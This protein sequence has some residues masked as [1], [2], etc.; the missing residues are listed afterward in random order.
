MYYNKCKSD[1]LC[2]LKTEFFSWIHMAIIYLF[3]DT[4]LFIQCKSLD[5]LDWSAWKAFDEIHL[6][7]S[8]PVQAEID[9][10]KGGGNSRLSHR[11][12]NT[13]SK[14][15]REILNSQEGYLELRNTRPVV[16]IYLRQ[17]LKRDESLAEQLD[18][19]EHDDQLVGI[20]SLFSKN[21]A[22]AE[23][24]VLTHDTGPMTTA[25]MVGVK[26][27][28]IPEIWLLPPE[29][30]KHEKQI[31]A[32]QREIDLLKKTEPEI[33]I[34]FENPLS[35]NDALDIQITHYTA[36][37]HVKVES[38]ISRIKNNIP[39]KTKFNLKEQQ[40][41]TRFH[42]M[43]SLLQGTFVPPT[44][45]EIQI[46]ANESYPNW[47]G[48]CEEILFYLHE[49]I[50]AKT[51]NPEVTVLL[52]NE[53]SRPA[54]DV[55]IT[56]SAKGDFKIQPPLDPDEGE[57]ED[58]FPEF[59][60]PLPPS[61]PSGRRKN[62]FA[63]GEL[64]SAFTR[65]TTS[66]FDIT[67]LT[68]PNEYRRDPNKF[69]YQSKPDTPVQAFSLTCSQWRHQDE[70]E[71]FIFTMHTKAQT[72]KQFSGELEIKVQAANLTNPIIMR[73][74]IKISFTLKSV[75]SEAE[76]L[77]NQLIRKSRF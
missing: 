35:S 61:P 67:R 45:E 60:L 46:Y 72:E 56:L 57:E 32:L 12:R 75:F 13:S 58:S 37:D 2:I 20:A 71:P 47:L 17:D 34:R 66:S 1:H 74:H 14:I 55:L 44:E 73:K 69:Y 29:A 48:K 42:H 30:T 39:L 76:K 6:L 26:F 27:T 8:R 31:K 36:L 15:F 63:L 7:V 21:N 59:E 77:V 5:E 52:S 70:E 50:N 19:N 62:L 43:S 24:R 10:H 38:L 4:N 23:V 51:N 22:D 54:E 64:M 11:A 18:Y 33:Q 16:R 3:P 9:K 65:T 41:D 53:G 40:D 28:E 25:K 68:M 49:K